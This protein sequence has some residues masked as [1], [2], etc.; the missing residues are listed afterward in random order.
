VSGFARPAARGRHPAAHRAGLWKWA[1]DWKAARYPGL[2]F[3]VRQGLLKASCADIIRA[4]HSQLT[5][6]G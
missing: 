2:F 5:H 6:G 1:V 4:Y 3:P